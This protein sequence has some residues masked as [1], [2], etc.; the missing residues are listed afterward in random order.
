[1]ASTGFAP[2]V[3]SVCKRNSRRGLVAAVL[4]AVLGV[5]P[6]LR[7]HGFGV[8]TSALDEREVRESLASADSMA[9]SLAARRQGRD[10]NDWR[11]A[12]AFSE[13]INGKSHQLVESG[14]R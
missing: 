4:R 10:A 7:L 3:G 8:K 9:W 2:G 11:E 6:D 14:A 1:M 5:R 13:R 12:V